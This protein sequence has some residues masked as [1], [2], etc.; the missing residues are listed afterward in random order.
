MRRHTVE[1]VAGANS[2][3]MT[4]CRTRCVTAFVRF[5]AGGAHE[6]ESAERERA[7]THASSEPRHCER[8]RADAVS[9]KLSANVWHRRGAGRL[10]RW[11]VRLEISRDL[12]RGPVRFET[13]LIRHLGTFP[14]FP[15]SP[16]AASDCRAGCFGGLTLPPAR[17]G[18]TKTRQAFERLFLR[19]REARAQDEGRSLVIV[20]RSLG[21]MR[22]FP[23]GTGELTML[24]L[25]CRVF[26]AQDTSTRLQ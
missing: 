22:S 26:A 15:T 1:L 20:A 25:V 3:T 23:A 11:G 19:I 14:R 8:A 10:S 12:C 17:R 16:R 18:A 13:T 5:N 6:F 7:R 9:R 21:Y 4:A 2:E 24:T